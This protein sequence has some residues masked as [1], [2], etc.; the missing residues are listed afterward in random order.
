MP[1]CP[2]ST[3]SQE[4][5]DFIVRHNSLSADEILSLYQVECQDYIDSEFSVIYIPLERVQPITIEKYTYNAI[6]KLY[7]LLDTT[8]M[9]AS[10]F[11][12]VARQPALGL[13]GQGTMI[14]FIDTGI[15]YQNP[16][17][18]N[19]DGSSRIL[20]IWD[21]TLTGENGEEGIPS[22]NPYLSFTYGREFT[23]EQLDQAL[24]EENPLLSVPTADT[25]GHGTFMAGIAAGG[26]LEEQDFTGA[27]PD[28]FLGVVKLKPAKKYLMDFYSVNP[29]APAYQEN[30][31]MTGIKYL[32]ILASSYDLPL[33]IYIGVG[34]NYGNHEGSSPL[35]RMLNSL[36]RLVGMCAVL[37]GGNEAGFRHHFL[38]TLTPNQEYEDVE[39]RVAPEERGFVT[40]LW[41]Q[42]PDLYRVGFISPTGQVIPPVPIGIGTE[43]SIP[44]SLEATVITLNYRI[45]EIGSGN[46]FILM[47]FQTPAAGIWH[48]RV[49][50]S[51]HI[52]GRFH[53]WLPVRGFIKDDTFFLRSE[54]DNTITEP[55]NA[56]NPITVSTYNHQNNSIYI[57]S[58][59][60]FTPSGLIKPDLA[61]P[62]VNVYGPGIGPSIEGTGSPMTRKTGSSVAAAHTAGA[63]ACL[64]TWG[65]GQGHNPALS[66]AT[67]R[68][69][70]IRGADRS[71]AYTYPNTEWGY[72]T[73]NLYQTF[74]RMR[75]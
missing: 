52:T 14:G 40:E 43:V 75:E 1:V 6:P 59:R 74:L 32:Q 17:F 58:S 12:Q 46:Q 56:P 47:R 51:L 25:S 62:G 34:T 49:Y 50:S 20:G 2:F 67:I 33:V 73:L 54:P 45:S 35:G 4:Y 66:D 18:R 22:D 39:I 9:E 60:G 19:P 10:G 7:T 29:S 53:M 38:G 63:V 15:D 48:I 16:C 31:I 13:T 24:R 26:V 28:C 44:F 65:I 55:A 42:G 11:T 57:H 36:G 61:A 41:A 72:G 21:Q 69:Y 5:A 37:A 64:V 71:P 8:S 3:A 68:A 30:D 23:K 27:A 70:L